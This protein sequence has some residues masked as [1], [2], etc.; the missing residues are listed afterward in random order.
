MVP[1]PLTTAIFNADGEDKVLDVRGL[2]GVALQLSGTF[3]LT[4]QFEA[5]VDGQTWVSL[6]MLPSN[7]TSAV[8]N[9]TAAGAWSANVAGFKHLRA[10]VSAYTSGSA[11][12]TILASSASGRVGSSGGGDAETLDGQ[13]GSYYLD[14]DN[15]TAGTL[16]VARGGTGAATHT[17]GSV[18]LG[19]GTGAITSTATLAVAKGGTGAGTHTSGSIL[20][21]AG[22]GAVTSTATL[23]VAKGGTGVGTHTSGNY[24]KG[25]GTGNVTSAT[26]AATFADVSPLTTRGDIL[27]SSSG[28]VTGARL[29][30]GGADEVLTS[31]GTDVAWA[32]A[33]GGGGKILQVVY[34]VSTSVVSTTDNIYEDT[35]LT[36]SITP[37]DDDNKILVLV[38]H[39]GVGKVTTNTRCHTQLLRDSTQIAV[40]NTQAFTGSTATMYTGSSSW[41]VLD[42]PQTASEIVYK[43]QFLSQDDTG[44]VYVGLSS[45]TSTIVLLEVDV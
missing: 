45:S 30:V 5:T 40:E 44:T 18:L 13:D 23:A 21:G 35:G 22:T 34:G 3:T 15:V 41:S 39:N 6:R 7:S 14:V 1:A 31:D 20:L 17:S 33:G 16:V 37:S 2:G 42:D 12:L 38:S 10:R 11:E 9:A 43:T 28:T 4:V 19:A 24:L 8:T 25:A 29:G 36:A 32:A 27:Y 26:P